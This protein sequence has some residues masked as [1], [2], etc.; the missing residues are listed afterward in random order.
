MNNLL[1]PNI[2][3]EVLQ[4]NGY[5]RNVAHNQALPLLLIE[6]PYLLTADQWLF[7]LDQNHK[8][9][10][11]LFGI[12]VNHWDSS[13]AEATK[14]HIQHCGD[15]GP[16]WR[17][18]AGVALAKLPC[19]P[20]ERYLL[21]KFHLIPNWIQEHLPAMPSVAPKKPA[22][23]KLPT[24]NPETVTPEALESL[25]ARPH[26]ERFEVMKETCNPELLRAMKTDPNENVRGRI[27]NNPC[28]PLEV[29]WELATQP[30]MHRRILKNPT[31]PDDLMLHILEQTPD[32]ISNI[33]YRPNPPAWALERAWR[34]SKTIKLE[35]MIL[36]R[37]DINESVQREVFLHASDHQVTQKHPTLASFVACQPSNADHGAR[38]RSPLWHIKLGSALH[39]APTSQ[40]ALSVLRQSTN[41]FV[42]AALRER[43]LLAG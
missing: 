22:L 4:A 36:A 28:T 30:N 41:M 14:F 9:P 35:E 3:P 37:D 12:L 5:N 18:V 1:N 7:Q 10:E 25:K 16:E 17:E 6:D 34:D 20:R 11:M 2:S 8:I 31:S 43:G 40:S 42:R 23:R 21:D 27:A 26:K 32:A 15:T 39:V 24:P 29:L 13:V 33:P 19:T 38:Y